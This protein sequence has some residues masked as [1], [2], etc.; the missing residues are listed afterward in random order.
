MTVSFIFVSILA[1]S[2]LGV[3]AQYFAVI[4]A[5]LMVVL[6]ACANGYFLQSTGWDIFSSLLLDITALQ[7]SY[8]LAASIEVEAWRAKRH[9]EAAPASQSRSSFA[10]SKKNSPHAAR[11][12][13]P[14]AGKA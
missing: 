10:L 1:G 13:T 3:F 2:L 4:A 6:I 11:S 9:D 8:F 12:P 7:V 14:G 5:S